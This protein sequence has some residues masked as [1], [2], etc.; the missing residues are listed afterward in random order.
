MQLSHGRRAQSAAERTTLRVVNAD[1]LGASEVVNREIFEL[2]ATGLVTSG[3]LM[4]NGPAFSDALDR[5]PDFPQCSFGV[6]L[7]LTAFRPLSAPGALQPI[8]ADGEFSRELLTRRAILSLR[9]ELEAELR[10]QVQRIVD[11]GVPVSHLDSHH[12]IH[13]RPA[14]FPVIKAVQ[15]HFGIRR[16]RS[17][18]QAI[19]A[20]SFSRKVQ[21][22][23]MNY[24]T[25]KV[26]T[27]ITPN[28]WC[29]FKSFY[30]ELT[31]RGMPQF[32]CLELMVHP[33]SRSPCFIEE[34][35]LLRSGWQARLPTG[36]RVVSYQFLNPV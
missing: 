35:N 32:H 6:H 30:E 17:S 11:S 24:A 5:I 31:L 26:Y 28:G 14:L 25:R 12:F 20:E 27:S 16:M 8:L 10:L 36:V 9:K 21:S 7:N 33:G 15:R 3:T 18:F 19:H 2:M 34:I 13:L 29:E 23:L 1:D 22:K 4:A